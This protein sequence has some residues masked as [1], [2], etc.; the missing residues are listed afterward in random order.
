MLRKTVQ[1]GKIDPVKPIT[2]RF[3]PGQTLDANEIFGYIA[4][5]Q[6]PKVIIDV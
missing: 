4:R 5:T 2:C 1:A 6:A 3:A